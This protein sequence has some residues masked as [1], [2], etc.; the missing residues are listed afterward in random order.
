MIKKTVMKQRRFINQKEK[1]SRVQSSKVPKPSSVFRR[2]LHRRRRSIA[3]LLYALTLHPNYSLFTLKTQHSKQTLK[4]SFQR[5]N[6]MKLYGKLS[7][8]TIAVSWQSKYSSFQF[9]SC[10]LYHH[11]Q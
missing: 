6:T 4:I 11:F 5:C 3:T 2:R 8:T 1:L 10:F 7:D 9:H